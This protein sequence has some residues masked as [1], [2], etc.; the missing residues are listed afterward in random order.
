M[1]SEGF[2][3]LFIVTVVAILVGLAD[4]L[5]SDNVH[6]TLDIFRANGYS[7]IQV[8]FTGFLNQATSWSVVFTSVRFIIRPNIDITQL[9]H[10]DVWFFVKVAA[11]LA[12]SEVAFTFC[13]KKLH[14]NK[15]MSTFHRFHH[16]CK[17]PSYSSN[18]WF[19]PVDFFLEH[20]TPIGAM[21]LFCM[22]LGDMKLYFWA[23][24]IS[25]TWYTADHD[26]LLQLPHYQHHRKVNRNF[27]I[28]LNMDD[29][30][31]DDKVLSSIADKTKQ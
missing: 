1:F 8:L 19:H 9:F 5:V 28:Y 17:W 16:C 20:A 31:K 4:L 3:P 7:K 13:H 27:N 29:P 10:L 18:M 12:I 14:T 26:E 22:V 30:S 6:K 24:A 2:S 25:F 11:S 23:L 15:T 21:L